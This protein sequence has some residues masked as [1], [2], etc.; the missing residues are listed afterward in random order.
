[1]DFTGKPLRGFVY[2]SPPGYRTSAALRTWVSRGER[3]AKREGDGANEASQEPEDWFRA[4]NGRA[5]SKSRRSS[6]D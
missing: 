1:M 2:V 3:V 4:A 6:T 5:I